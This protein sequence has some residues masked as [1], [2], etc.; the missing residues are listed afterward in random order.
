MEQSI[1]AHL[2]PKRIII[3]TRVTN[4]YESIWTETDCISILT[5][6]ISNEELG[7]IALRHIL[8]STVRDIRGSES[9]DLRRNYYRLCKFK[10]EGQAMKD[11]RMVSVFLTE[12]SVRFEPRNN[13][14]SQIKRR[15][16]E[17]QGMPEA[18]F[19]INYPCTPEVIGVNLRKA[20][21]AA[22]IT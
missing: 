16:Y 1:A 13:R 18:I 7:V 2:Y 15:Y 11:S 8:L 10:T 3:S 17:Y 21:E 14:Y 9:M 5:P 22:L 6:E 12:H 4:E 20:W 19:S